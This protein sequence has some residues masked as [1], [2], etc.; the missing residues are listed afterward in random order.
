[1]LVGDSWE[2]CDRLLAAS[3]PAAEACAEEPHD[4]MIPAG[5]IVS[6]QPPAL[7]TGLGSAVD[8]LLGG[9]LQSGNLVEVFGAAG[10]GKTQLALS[11]AA[12]CAA[13]GVPTIYMSAKDGLTD[14][15]CRLCTILSARGSS[16]ETALR[17]VHLVYASDFPEFAKLL[18]ACAA[19][20][21]LKGNADAETPP[22]LIIDGISVLLA[23]FTTAR[24]W[25]H[26]WRLAWTWRTL[27]QLATKLHI[28]VLML[29]HTVGAPQSGGAAVTQSAL[30]QVWG[31][32]ASTRLVLSEASDHGTA[33]DCGQI[34][35]LTTRKSVNG[36]VGMSACLVLNERGVYAD[37][38]RATFGEAEHQGDGQL[39]QASHK[40]EVL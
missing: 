29:S 13:I 10:V 38:T 12:H 14:L 28:R 31:T 5:C 17:K 36:P 33:G 3:V 8:G 35:E 20:E 34:I 22:L 23:P 6:K 9:G 24:G 15:A 16:P 19:G 39:V 1:M 7:A 11:I 18:T 21:L 2:Q 27:R 32:A 40:P 26:R 37:T 4:H 25:G 30:G